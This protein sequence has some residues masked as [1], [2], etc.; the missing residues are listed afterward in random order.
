MYT[1]TTCETIPYQEIF[2]TDFRI[3]VALDVFT[4]ALSE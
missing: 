4:D 3:S 1:L 2:F